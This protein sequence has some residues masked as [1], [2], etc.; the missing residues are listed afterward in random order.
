VTATS[1]VA[2]VSRA[3]LQRTEQPGRHASIPTSES[4]LNQ[5]PILIRRPWLQ[6][7]FTA[8]VLPFLGLAL[9]IVS[10]GY[11]Y[12]LSTYQPHPPLSRASVLRL[13]VD[14]RPAAA[15]VASRPGARPHRPVPTEPSVEAPARLARHS[16]ALR[17]VVPAPLRGIAISASLI[18]FRAPPTPSLA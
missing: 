10:W 7:L 1:P 6:Q 5:D 13:W 2:K 18:P 8:D 14:Q 9:I 16:Q 11:G 3:P 4:L 15:V 17:Y 12:K